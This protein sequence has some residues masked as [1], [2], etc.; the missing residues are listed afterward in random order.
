M[1]VNIEITEGKPMSISFLENS[2]QVEED[3]D[4]SEIENVQ[5]DDFNED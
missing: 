2:V 5:V 4:I 3:L 1:I